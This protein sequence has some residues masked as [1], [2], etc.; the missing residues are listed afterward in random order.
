[1][2]NEYLNRINLDLIKSEFTELYNGVKSTFSVHSQDSLPSER[3]L[4]DLIFGERRK[5][6]ISKAYNRVEGIDD[7]YIK[8]IVNRII[9]VSIILDASNNS[10]NQPPRKIDTTQIWSLIYNSLILFSANDIIATVG[11]QGFLSIP[12]YHQDKKEHSFDFLRLHIWDN[13]LERYIDKKRTELFSIHCHQFHAQSWI[14]CGEIFNT[15]YTV[16]ENLNESNHHYFE[17]KWKNQK[18][19][20]NRKTSIAVKTNIPVTLTAKKLEKYHTGDTYEITAGEFHRTR[21][22]LNEAISSTVFLFSTKK[23]RVI[24]S[25]VIGPSHIEESEINRN[26]TIDAKYLLT[27]IN[28]IIGK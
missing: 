15:R 18:N 24:K 19:N 13:S 14:L 22:N 9:A 4:L 21:V 16:K 23:G 8:S 2:T 12:L 5:I 25:Y 27:K 6:K 7:L 20:V 11:S 1:M 10:P 26:V 17:I 28:S 3:S